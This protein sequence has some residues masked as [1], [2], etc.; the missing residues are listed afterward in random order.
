VGLGL[1]EEVPRRFQWHPFGLPDSRRGVTVACVPESVAALGPRLVGDDGSEVCR[2]PA[3]RGTVVA[4]MRA[5]G[6]DREPGVIRLTLSELSGR[7]LVRFPKVRK[8]TETYGPD[9]VVAPAL[10]YELS[11]F[12]VGADQSSAIPGLFMAGEIVGGTH[13]QER[14][15]GNGVADSLV[16]GHRAG[17]AAAEAVL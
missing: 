13:G 5:W 9:P 7:D 15:M 12:P 10:H 17:E 16:H 11:G 6:R 3:P 14:L 1:V 4:A 2:L 8:Q